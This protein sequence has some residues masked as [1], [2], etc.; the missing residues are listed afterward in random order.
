MTSGVSQTMRRGREVGS[1]VTKLSE[2]M[3]AWRR[4]N[5]CSKPPRQLV[6]ML[7]CFTTGIACFGPTQTAAPREDC[8]CKFLF[9][10]QMQLAI[11]F[12]S[13]GKPTREEQ[14]QGTE[15]VHSSN[16]IDQRHLSKIQL[17]LWVNSSCCHGADDHCAA[18]PPVPV[19]ERSPSL[20]CPC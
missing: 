1:Q 7:G 20:G 8:C 14:L 2:K 16:L 19:P 6:T 9:G 17:R 12:K 10:L 18:A 4:L 11:Q 3:E 5:F 15:H 13:P